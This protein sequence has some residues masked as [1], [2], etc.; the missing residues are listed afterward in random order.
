MMVLKNSSD[1]IEKLRVEIDQ[2]FN[3]LINQLI[4]NDRLELAEQLQAHKYAVFYSN[5]HHTLKKGDI[6]FLGLN[7]AGKLDAPQDFSFKSKRSD[8]LDYLDEDWEK[9]ETHRKRIL[10]VLGFTLNSLSIEPL[11]EN[12]RKVFATNMYFFGSPDASTLFRYGINADFFFNW[13]FKFLEI[14]QP[15]IIICNGNGESVQAPY[16]SLKKMFDVRKDDVRKYYNGFSLKSF[17][18][19]INGKDTLVIG[20]PHLSRYKLDNKK[21]GDRFYNDMREIIENSAKST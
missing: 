21:V 17:K 5:P 7:P 14:V 13:H 19:S 16:G 10:E 12:L 3:D 20:L 11:D 4:G 1:T 2:Y 15:K 8:H 6:Y 18:V 9:G